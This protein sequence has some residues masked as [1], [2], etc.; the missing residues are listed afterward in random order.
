MNIRTNMVISTTLLEHVPDNAKSIKS[1]YD[2][3]VGGGTTHHYI[4]SKWHPY[5]V[6]LRLVGP[7]LQKK[8]IAILRPAAADVTG[9][10]AFFS[11]C[12]PGG[13]RKV[14]LNNGFQDVE[15]NPFYRA[16]D[17]FAFFVP[18]FLIITLYENICALLN[19]HIAS[20]GF[21]ISARKPL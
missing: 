16:N 13:M 14:F 3:L 9:Y 19:I 20:S 2:S 18:A 10:P 17:Y 1:I 11:H 8:L 6:A 5:S 7:T 21:V 15:V 12:S 4:P